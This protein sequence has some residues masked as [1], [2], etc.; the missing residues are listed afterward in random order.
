MAID[1]PSP[2]SFVLFLPSPSPSSLLHDSVVAS[3][4]TVALG[5]VSETVVAGVV[6][7][8]AVFFFLF[9]VCCDNKLFLEE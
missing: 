6:V 5:G 1:I 2:S 3:E 4:S 8:A 7:A 9:S